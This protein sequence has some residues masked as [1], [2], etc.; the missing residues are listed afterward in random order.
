MELFE[1]KRYEEALAKFDEILLIDTTDQEALRYRGIARG[2]AAKTSYQ[3]G[4]SAMEVGDFAKAQELLKQALRYDPDNL[5]IRRVYAQ[6]EDRQTQNKRTESQKTYRDA[7]DA[8][9]S[10]DME[11]SLRWARKSLELDSDNLEAKR[12][13]ERLTQ[14][15]E[16]TP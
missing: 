11:N 10:G 3:D 15:R 13:I 2:L 4:L 1:Q 7:L 9:L 6:V 14:R 12:L 5:D 16:N 8:F